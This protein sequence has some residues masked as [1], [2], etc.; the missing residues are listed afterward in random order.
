MT[1]AAGGPS[2]RI[3]G[4]PVTR[5]PGESRPAPSSN[6][7][8]DGRRLRVVVGAG[9]LPRS[10]RLLLLRPLV[11]REARREAGPR[12]RREGALRPLPGS[13]ALP[14]V[15]ARHEG[16]ARGLGRSERDGA[17]GGP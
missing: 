13:R 11:L 14:R 16:P 3:Y 10:G 8:V 4:I 2:D 15:R 9:G 5:D 12:G 7:G 17:P 1:E 6:Y